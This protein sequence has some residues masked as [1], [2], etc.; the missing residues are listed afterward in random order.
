MAIIFTEKTLRIIILLLLIVSS[1]L[2]AEVKEF[3]PPRIEGLRLDSCL[4]WGKDCK[5]PAAHQFCIMNGFNK[6]IHFEIEENIGKYQP[7]KMLDSRKICNKE[8]CDAFKTIFCY[9]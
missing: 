9:K 2:H 5:E 4:S 3:E 6:S 7:T 1:A 8:F